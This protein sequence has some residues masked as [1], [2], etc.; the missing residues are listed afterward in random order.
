MSSM[1]DVNLVVSFTLMYTYRQA[2]AVVVVV[3]IEEVSNDNI[4]VCIAV[5]VIL[6]RCRLGDIHLGELDII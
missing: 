3:L 1:F 4:A 6:K 5:V 2:V